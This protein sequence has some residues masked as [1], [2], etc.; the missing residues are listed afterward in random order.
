[1]LALQIITAIL[2]ILVLVVFVGAFVCYRIVFYSPSINKRKKSLIPDGAIYEEHREDMLAWIDKAN[3]MPYKNVSV[4][5]FDGLTL[6]GRYYEYSK[7]APLEILLH[8]YKGSSLRDLSGG[9]A[10]CF[11]LGHSALIVDHRGSGESEGHVIS[12]GINESRDC[13]TWVDYVV[14]NINPDVKIILTGISMGAATVMICAAQDFPENVVGVLADCGYTSAKEII[15]KVIREMGLSPEFFYPLVRL[16]ARIWGRF[17][18]H[19]FSPIEAMKKS[20][21]PVIFFHGDTDDFVPYEMS[22]ENYEACI[23]KKRLVKIEGA[24][25]GL[26]FVKNKAVYLTELREFFDPMLG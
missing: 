20:R 7:D 16:G 21:L 25:H 12:F 13:H 8:G 22:A 23:T 4:R 3:T 2:I 9:I 1:M 26:C 14:K 10:R 5:S 15:K 17:D 19:E 11:K 18:L 24:G 6:R